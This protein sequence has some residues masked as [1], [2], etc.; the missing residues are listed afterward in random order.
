MEISNELGLIFIIGMTIF[1]MANIAVSYIK[2]KKNDG[3]IDSME[4]Q[5]LINIIQLKA[6]ELLQIAIDIEEVSTKGD[7]YLIDYV[8]DQLYIIVIDLDIP[9]AQKDIITKSFL[10]NIVMRL[11]KIFNIV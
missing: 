9:D 8:V 10:K 3:N 7:D 6:L 4:S 5:E 1:A 2:M 11:K